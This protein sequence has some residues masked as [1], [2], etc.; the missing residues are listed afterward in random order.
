MSIDGIGRGGPPGGV[1][2]IA[3]ALPAGG[4]PEIGGAS[5]SRGVAGSE[6]LGQLQRGELSLSQYLDVTVQ[7]AVQHL[8]GK[9]PSEQLGFVRAELRRQ[10]ESDPA[11]QE[12]VR[13]TTGQAPGASDE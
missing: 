13:R 12:L 2:S 7:Q 6:A 1:A 5:S 8:Q 4:A 11:L 10:L 9:L 3:D